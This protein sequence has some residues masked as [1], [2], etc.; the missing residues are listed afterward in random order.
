MVQYRL[1]TAGQ[2]EV[3]VIGEIYNSR[4]IRG[5]RIIQDY[6]IAISQFISDLQIQI[7][8]K[9]S[10]KV[11]AF[12]R[13]DN[14]CRVF[15]Y[16]KGICFEYLSIESPASAM[17]RI[18]FTVLFKLKD[19]GI[20]AKLAMLDSIGKSAYSGTKFRMLSQITF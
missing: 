9:S 5:C 11:S 16:I 13:K 6:F 15:H 12:I 2:I 10:F 1:F 20:Q 17:N 8:R 7:A 3:A 18:Y 4:L 14:Y 19:L